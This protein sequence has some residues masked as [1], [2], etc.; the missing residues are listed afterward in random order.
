MAVLKDDDIVP[1]FLFYSSL[2]SD[3][4]LDFDFDIRD[5][6]HLYKLKLTHA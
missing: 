5:V 1:V 6:S 2:R 4:C 3:L